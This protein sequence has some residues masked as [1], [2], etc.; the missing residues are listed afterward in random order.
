MKSYQ[1]P[2]DELA[3]IKKNSSKT[4]ES[5]VNFRT[6]GSRE[7]EGKTWY[8]LNKIEDLSKSGRRLFQ[9]PTALYFFTAIP[10]VLLYYLKETHTRRFLWLIHSQS[11]DGI[12]KHYLETS[13][14]IAVVGLS[15]REETT[16]HRC[17]ARRC[18][19]GDMDYSVNPAACGQIAG[20]TV[21]LQ[22]EFLSQ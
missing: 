11:S 16:S 6:T 17:P 12:I 18:K 4:M 9:F 10:F 13:K 15:D 21:Y 14:I 8:G 20:E 3:A 5:A 7:N 19:I 22:Q 2:S 1:V